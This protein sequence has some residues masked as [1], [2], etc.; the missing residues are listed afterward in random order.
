MCALAKRGRG[1]N[2]GKGC[3]RSGWCQI[4]ASSKRLGVVPE[5]GAEDCGHC[6]TFLEVVGRYDGS[7]RA[8][9]RVGCEAAL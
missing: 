9:D 6:V 1:R 4:L 7:H 5:W 2:V 3:F 8:P